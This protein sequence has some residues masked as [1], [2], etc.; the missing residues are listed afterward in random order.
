MKNAK[1]NVIKTLEFDNPYQIPIQLWDLPWANIHY[2]NEL[3]NIKEKFPS[4][5]ISA[6]D[7]LSKTIKTKGDEYQRRDG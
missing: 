2:P 4:D 7:L 3:R 5:I 6:P 1:N